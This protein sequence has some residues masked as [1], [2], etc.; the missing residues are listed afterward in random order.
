MKQETYDLLEGYMLSCC[1]DSAH[2]A[3]HIYRVLYNALEI[4]GDGQDVD[5]DVLIAACLLHDIG[6]KVQLED[7]TKCHAQVGSQ[8]AHEFLLNNGFSQDFADRVAHCIQVHRFRKRQ[9]PQTQEARIL[10]D[11]DKLDVTGC[12]GIARTLMYKGNLT[13]PLYTKRPDGT[14][15]DGSGD[16]PSFFREYRFKLEKLYGQFCTA[17]G[18]ALARE[19][20][21]A[22]VA[23]YENLY[24]E[25]SCGYTAGTQRLRELLEKE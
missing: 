16:G 7:P 2:D 6:R 17:R 20:Q 15:C 5:M 8:M 9:Q 14:I 12:L 19:R 22:A 21:A 11:A 25:V 3:E 13:E 4:A 24:R 10:F 18:E 23:F 1:A